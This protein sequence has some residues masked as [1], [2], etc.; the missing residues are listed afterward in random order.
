MANQDDLSDTY[1]YMDRFFRLT[2]GDTADIT[3]AM[4][5]GD[6]S[7]TLEQAQADKHRFILESLRMTKGTRLLDIGCGWGPLLNAGRKAGVTGVGLTLSPKQHESGRRNGFE[8]HLEDWKNAR[9]SALGRFDGVA[10]VGAFE[11]F[12]SVADCQAGQQEIIYRRFFQLCSE[13]MPS[14]G[15]LFLQTLI[16]GPK[17]PRPEN[18]NVHAPKG[19]DAYLVGVLLKFYPGSW[20]P[21]SLGQI[22]KTAQPFFKLVSTNNGRRDYIETLDQWTRRTARP[23]VAKLIEAV[24][25]FPRFLS[26]RDFRYKMESLFTGGGHGCLTKRTGGLRS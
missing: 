14:Q 20:L 7:K 16:W 21:L 8:M 25:L 17:G 3:C 1:D 10:S 19:S 12:V 4:Y 13:V 18:A 23:S 15:R 11:H 2:L 9:P 5:N 6:F 24:K 26:S 22:E